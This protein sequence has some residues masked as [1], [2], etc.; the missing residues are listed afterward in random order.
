VARRAADSHLAAAQE[1]RCLRAARQAPPG[2]GPLGRTGVP[3]QKG[4]TRGGGN[5]GGPP[6]AAH[7]RAD[8]TALLFKTSV[9]LS[10]PT[11]PARG[12]N[13]EPFGRRRYVIV[14]LALSALA[15]ADTQV[16]L[17]GLAD[18]VLRDSTEPELAA[19]RMTFTL[20]SRT[21]RA[22]LVAVVRLLLGWGVLSRVSGDEDAYLAAGMDVLYDVR[23]QVLGVQDDSLVPVCLCRCRSPLGFAVCRIRPPELERMRRSGHRHQG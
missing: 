23:R 20:D 8:A 10:D 18:D 12:H 5:R 4:R 17:G 1:D 15:L 22:D 21:D 7:H 2:T 11:H 16:T 9:L 6:T 3:A 19:A 13:K 14:C